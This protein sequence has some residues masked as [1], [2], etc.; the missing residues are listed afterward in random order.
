M[1]ES[2]VLVASEE[3]GSNSI[4]RLELQAE[5]GRALGQGTGRY[6]RH[7]PFDPLAFRQEFGKTVEARR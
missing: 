4:A 2:R 1:K 7:G 6:Y 5:F 3:L